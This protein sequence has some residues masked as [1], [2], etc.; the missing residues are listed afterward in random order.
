MERVTSKREKRYDIWIPAVLFTVLFLFKLIFA[1]NARS[2]P[3]VSDEFLY[4]RFSRMLLE[5]GTYDSVQ[6]PLLY[7]LYLIPALFFGDNFYVAMKILGAFS[8][9]FVPIVVYAIARLYL[10]QRESTL[11]A[12]F[13][14]VI[15]FHYVTTMTLMSENLYFPMFLLAVYV[16]L[17]DFKHKIAGDIFL[18][19][20]LGLMFMTRHITFVSIPVFLFGWLLKQLDHKESLKSILL[21]GILVV[22]ALLAAYSPWFFMCRSYGHGMKEIVGFKIASKTNPEQLTLR[23]LVMSAGF[24]AAYFSLIL[25]P[26]L[27]LMFKSI[28]ALE[29]KKK[30]WF[31]AYNR[32]WVMVCGLAAAFFV[33]VTRHSWR[34]YYNYPEFAKIK[35]RYLIYFPILFVI[36]GAVVLFQKKPRF[37]HAWI[38]VAATYVLP[39][40]MIVGAYLVD[41]QGV[42]YPLHPTKF[43][44]SIESTDGQ[45]IKLV[46]AAFMVVLPLFIWIF[47][48]L[49]D[50]SREKWR[51]YLFPVFAAGLLLTEIWGMRPYMQ[52]LEEVDA[53]HRDTNYKYAD[54]FVE[55]IQ[56]IGQEGTIYVYVDKMP[57]YTYI[58]R[59]ADFW[60]VKN[61]TLTDQMEAIGSGTYY[62]FTNKLDKYKDVM[63]E[64]TAEFTWADKTYYLIKVQE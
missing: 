31:C 59:Y 11:C 13:S 44:G 51:K 53:D 14:M 50:F 28:R 29:L 41:I 40:A 23:R 56:G 47:Q 20:L 49:Y 7:P 60:Q 26:V 18:G 42:L 17:R 24:Y 6:Y 10:G 30:K 16:V 27:G 39:A 58:S 35:G 34:A 45:K 62:V 61:L 48:F 19:V 33:A 3:Q 21:R 43:I 22:A 38:N 63:T 32:L 36:L 2:M 8:S 4:A 46:G 64:Q 9:S 5:N 57:Q 25:A 15:P 55:A 37:K 12:G 54:E 52:Y 1:V